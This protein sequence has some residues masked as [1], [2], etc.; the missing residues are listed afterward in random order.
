MTTTPECV[1]RAI[2]KYQELNKQRIKEYKA[3]YYQEN[4]E[5]IKAAKKAKYAAK[6]AQMKQ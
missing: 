3:K 2:D 6:K 1:R 5:T 4:K